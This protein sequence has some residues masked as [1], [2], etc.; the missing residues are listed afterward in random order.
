MLGLFIQVPIIHKC[1]KFS[2]RKWRSTRLYQVQRRSYATLNW[3]VSDI[4]Y[5]I[6][7]KDNVEQYGVEGDL[8]GR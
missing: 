7:N 3:N 2:H 6:S 4:Y 5:H 8:G 1:P